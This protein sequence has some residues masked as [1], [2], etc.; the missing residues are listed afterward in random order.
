MTCDSSLVSLAIVDMLLNDEATATDKEAITE[1][2][3]S[4]GNTSYL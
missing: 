3:S 2:A 4:A 1:S